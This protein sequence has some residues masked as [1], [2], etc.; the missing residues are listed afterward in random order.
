[1]YAHTSV[2]AISIL[3]ADNDVANS[4]YMATAA[5]TTTSRTKAPKERAR[6]TNLHTIL[7]STCTANIIFSM[8]NY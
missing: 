6:H 8:T 7:N 4:N 5:H 2:N 3:S 1:M